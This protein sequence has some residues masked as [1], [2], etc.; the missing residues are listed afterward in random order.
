MDLQVVFLDDQAGPHDFEQFTLRNGTVAAFDEREQEVERP[1]SDNGGRASDEQLSGSGWP[2]FYW[3][4]P[5][6]IHSPDSPLA[7]VTGVWSIGKCA[8][9]GR[10]GWKQR[11]R[12]V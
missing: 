7:R 11:F 2:D 10:R 6:R 9:S 1:S 5:M 3:A 4:E 12:T 8:T